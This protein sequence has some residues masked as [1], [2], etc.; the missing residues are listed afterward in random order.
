MKTFEIEIASTTYRTYFIDSS[1]QDDAVSRAFDEM[2]ADWE[3]SK[4]WKQNAE[5]AF[6][7]EQEKESE[8]DSME[9]DDSEL[10][11]LNQDL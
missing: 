8:E 2:E 10:D 11:N 3:I 5:V 4:A 9:L 1:S 7:E 6:V